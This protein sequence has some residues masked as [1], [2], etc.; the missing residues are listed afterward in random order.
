[1]QA[2]NDEMKLHR[3]LLD[4][5]PILLAA[6][7]E[8]RGVELTTTLHRD[9]VTELATALGDPASVQEAIAWLPPDQRA[10]LDA[11]SAAGGRLPAMRFCR[12]HG[13]VRRMGPGRMERE[14]P[15]RD[16]QSPAEALYYAG[17]MFFAFDQLE[18]QIVEVVLVPDDLQP[19]LPPVQAG[20]QDLAVT[21]VP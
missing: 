2:P 14:K 7:A 15:W 17:L 4:H 12:D 18:D 13:D 5:N 8:R 3:A 19:L 11:L 6:I 16:P 9:R 1:M 20:A 10:A 21:A